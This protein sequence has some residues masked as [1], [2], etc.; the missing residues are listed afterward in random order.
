MPHT[1]KNKRGRILNTAEQVKNK[2]DHLS[3]GL[4]K[5][6]YGKIFNNRPGPSVMA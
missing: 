1:D 2:K 3:N 6:G 5:M 4:F